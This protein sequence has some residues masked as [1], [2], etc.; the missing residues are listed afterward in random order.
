MPARLLA[1]ALAHL[2]D[3]LRQQVAGWLRSGGAALAAAWAARPSG[4]RAAAIL[5]L[6]GLGAAGLAALLAQAGLPAR[7]P[8]PRD[9]Q[10]AGA[11]L[12]RDARP[13]DAVV[14]APSWL[15]RARE[16]VPHGLPV[17]AARRLD[18]ER[19][20]GVLRAWLLAAPGAPLASGAAAADLARRA[21]RADAQRLGGLEVVRFDLA[22]P[23]L[24]LA[25]L[26]DRA[27]PPARAALREAGGLPRRCL[28]LVPE[29]GA[30]LVLPFPAV[31]LGRTLSG[32]AALLP[33][34]G[35][36][37][38]RLAFQVDGAE[39]GAVE[40]RPADGWL[41]WQ[42]DT[43]RSAFGDHE[44]TVVATT[45]GAAARPVCLEALALP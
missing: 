10:A 6:A 36:G 7:L 40:L 22:A 5:T 43:S 21:A 45:A 34:P 3:M 18:G 13:G 33:G 12:S 1:S 44:V 14:V 17:L 25:V 20:P 32:H 8:S 28:L 35:E 29:P 42:V 38:V 30:P 26:A 37:P 23:V 15:E 31:R 39:A 16:V 27:P 19:L 9:W 2:K 11:L 24:P 41:A 4:R